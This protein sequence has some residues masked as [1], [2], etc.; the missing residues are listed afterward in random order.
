M[1]VRNHLILCHPVLLL[2]SI[3]PSI[4]VFSSESAVCIR[5][6]KYWSFSISPSSE[7]SGLISFW[8]AHSF[9]GLPKTLC[10][11]KAVIHKGD[12]LLCCSLT[13]GVFGP[14]PLWT[15]PL[16][17]TSEK[18]PGTVLGFSVSV[19][20]CTQISEY[21]GFLRLL[22]SISGKRDSRHLWLSFW[23]PDRRLF[24]VYLPQS[25]LGTL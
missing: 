2:P 25:E 5:W 18:E 12:Y 7:Y 13:L 23:I 15:E 4:K 21:S 17:L 24:S 11:D 1:I 6:L 16:K 3:F 19:S 14:D 22:P 8:M 10:D 20:L 9:T